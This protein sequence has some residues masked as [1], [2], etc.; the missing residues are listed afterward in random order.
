MTSAL[1][2]Q[3]EDRIVFTAGPRSFSVRDV[4]DAAYFRS[5]IEAW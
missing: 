5:S 1:P 3:K 2:A 4:I